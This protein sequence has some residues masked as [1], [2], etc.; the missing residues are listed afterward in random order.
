MTSGLARY[1]LVVA[2]VIVVGGVLLSLAFRGPGDA[3]A[4]WVSAVLALAVQV[5]AAALGGM[6][7]K[8]NLQ[9]RMGAGALV[10]FLTLIAYALVVAF[11]IKL[12]LTAALVSLA[13]FFFVTTLIEPLLIRS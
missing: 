13:V 12:P 10:R 4:I 1:T 9:A 3:T 7:G 8:A 5:G 11:A 6:I 2:G